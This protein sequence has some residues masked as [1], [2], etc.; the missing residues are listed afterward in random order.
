MKVT[1]LSGLLAL[2]LVSLAACTSEPEPTSLKELSQKTHFHGIAFDPSNPRQIYLA[3]HHGF[4]VVNEEGMA[5]QVSEQTDDFMGFTPRPGVADILYASGHPQ[6]GGNMGVMVSTDGGKTWEQ[7]AQG[8]NGPV[9]FHQMTASKAN[10][11]FLYGAHA[12]RLQVSRDGGHEWTVQ[13][14][15]PEGLIALTASAKDADHLYGATQTG[16]QMSPNGGERWRL[17]HP[18]RRPVS[19]VETSPGGNL[20]AF[21]L[22]AGLIQSEEGVYDWTVLNNDWGDGYLLHLAVDPN[23]EERLVAIDQQSRILLSEDGGR[24]WSAQ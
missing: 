5:R 14:A 2:L 18:Q 12:G 13:G 10:P 16:L 9:D 19:V 3:T 17:I 11:D 24:N 1:Y 15:A 21:M 7:R 22:G 20:Y 8:V 23:N 6:G 4:H